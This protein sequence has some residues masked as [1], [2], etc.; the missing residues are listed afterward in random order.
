MKTCDEHVTDL[1]EDAVHKFIEAEVA[2]Y[3]QLRGGIEFIEAIPKSAAGKILR[4]QLRDLY[5]A[6]V[7]IANWVL[8]KRGLDGDNS[9][10]KF[11]IKFRKIYIIIF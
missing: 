4:R 3:K 9:F 2:D 8:Y 1:D 7:C 6:W 5:A 11:I 10:L